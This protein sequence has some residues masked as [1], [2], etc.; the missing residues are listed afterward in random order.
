VL[1]PCVDAPRVAARPRSRAAAPLATGTET[2]LLVEDEPAVRALVAELLQEAGYRVREAA[3]AR[4]AEAEH[5]ADGK[6]DL[7][8]TDVV[9]PDRNGREL[10]ESLS[11]RDPGLRVLFMSGYT[12]DDVLRQGLPAEIPLV[13]KPMRADELLRSIRGALERR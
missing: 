3:T 8:L 12:D 9:L 6:I 10:F 13:R 7:L 1:I 5:A 2:I 11:A 4:A